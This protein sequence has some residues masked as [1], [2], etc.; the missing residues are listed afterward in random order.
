MATKKHAKL[1]ISLR[2]YEYT[3]TFFARV[4][5]FYFLLTLKRGTAVGTTRESD[6]GEEFFLRRKGG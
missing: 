6:E 5:T 4:R 1:R 2:S 3:R